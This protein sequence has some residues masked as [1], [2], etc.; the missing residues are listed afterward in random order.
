MPRGQMEKE[1]IRYP[2]VVKG[3]VIP[4]DGLDVP[5]LIMFEIFHV[6]PEARDPVKPNKN[7][8]KLP[9]PERSNFMEKREEWLAA[10]F[11]RSKKPRFWAIKMF[12]HVE[13]KTV[14]FKISAEITSSQS[15]TIQGKWTLMIL[16][17][18]NPTGSKG[19]K[20]FGFDLFVNNRYF[21]N[22]HLPSIGFWTE[23]FA[24]FLPIPLVTRLSI[25]QYNA[26]TAPGVI[27]I[28]NRH[29]SYE[30]AFKSSDKTA[31]QPPEDYDPPAPPGPKS[32]KKIKMVEYSSAPPQTEYS[33]KE[34][35][36]RETRSTMEAILE[37]LESAANEERQVEQ[38]FVQPK[39][40]KNKKQ[41]KHPQEPKE[42][43]IDQDDI[44]IDSLETGLLKHK[45]LIVPQSPSSPSSSSSS[46]SQTSSS[47]ED[48]FQNEPMPDERQW[49]D[50]NQEFRIELDQ[51]L[52]AKKLKEIRAEQ[53]KQW[54]ASNL[55]W[56][57]KNECTV[58][59]VNEVKAWNLYGNLMDNPLDMHDRI[60]SV[61][62]APPQY[63]F[64][65]EYISDFGEAL[66]NTMDLEL[67][68][69]GCVPWKSLF[70]FDLYCMTFQQ[71]RPHWIVWFTET[72]SL[73]SDYPILK[74]FYNWKYRKAHSRDEDIPKEE[75]EVE[76]KVRS[77]LIVFE[78]MK[79]F[80]D[81]FLTDIKPKECDPDKVWNRDYVASLYCDDKF[82]ARF[83][84]PVSLLLAAGE[85]YQ[86]RARM[87][88]EKD[89]N[90]TGMLDFW[91]H[92]KV[93][94]CQKG[95]KNY[96][97]HPKVM[98]A[99]QLVFFLCDAFVNNED[100][101]QQLI[102]EAENFSKEAPKNVE[103]EYRVLTISD[104]NI[105]DLLALRRRWDPKIPEPVY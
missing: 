6:D 83:T 57:H 93:W 22:Q 60:I 75:T 8:D 94:I 34:M 66:T 78:K 101:W 33:D 21:K 19:W 76:D 40:K 15:V 105:M 12:D 88:P 59:F 71:P 50:H 82:G 3:R 69:K 56:H 18:Y 42:V 9:N 41:K 30:T 2:V 11:V 39:P 37:D 87:F 52:I 67:K 38:D 89:E 46:S 58:D 64:K 80:E 61:I 53:N 85:F 10:K 99:S 70:T 104:Q 65:I 31:N 17:F 23:S 63:P 96:V 98:F 51:G 86:E 5:N 29:K 81:L 1:S 44:T 16:Q 28:G 43:A 73:P 62:E 72:P 26:L 35:T 95:E 97:M 25:S 68:P 7:P 102:E 32:K 84:N 77:R 49:I 20:K 13:K 103:A 27:K 79:S 24:N 91:V 55:K 74:A 36:I 92:W 45:N 100:R 14:A 54:A 4:K 48:M 90:L 47:E